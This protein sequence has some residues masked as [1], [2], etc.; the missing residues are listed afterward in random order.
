MAQLLTM[1]R[2]DMILS[3]MLASL[4]TWTY[5]LVKYGGLTWFNQQQL[6]FLMGISCG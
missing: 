1:A 6:Q 4:E 5:F 3:H 2:M